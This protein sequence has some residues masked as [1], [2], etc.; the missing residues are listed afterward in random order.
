MMKRFVE[1]YKI[2]KMISENTVKLKLL[3]S[4]KIHPVVNISRITMHK[5]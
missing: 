2:N 4:I 1:P 5:E 3:E